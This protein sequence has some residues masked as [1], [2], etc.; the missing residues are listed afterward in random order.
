MADM[1]S[2]PASLARPDWL[3]RQEMIYEFLAANLKFESNGIEFCCG[4]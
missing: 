4:L 3:K 1:L 2:G